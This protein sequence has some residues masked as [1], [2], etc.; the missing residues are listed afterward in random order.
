MKKS[1]IIVAIIA[2]ILI[3]ACIVTCVRIDDVPEVTE[4]TEDIT[5]VDSVKI[6][7]MKIN[8][9]TKETK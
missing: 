5:T 4:I 7:S 9:T 8:K 1:N 3:T 2:S 6:D